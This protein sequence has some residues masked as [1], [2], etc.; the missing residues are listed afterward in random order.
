MDRGLH[1]GGVP[2]PNCSSV[3]AG[4]PRPFWLKTS[5]FFNIPTSKVVGALLIEPDLLNTKIFFFLK[6]VKICLS[7]GPKH[8]AKTGS[9]TKFCCFYGHKLTQYQY[10]W[11]RLI[12][13]SGLNYVCNPIYGRIPVY[14]NVCFR[15]EKSCKNGQNC[16][17]PDLR[18]GAN[19]KV[20]SFFKIFASNFHDY[21]L[22]ASGI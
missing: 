10:F 13:K 18:V 15:P 20:V 11:K 4:R 6:L 14:I 8:D 5:N 22:S 17:Y 7:Y 3:L 21:C 9:A 1:F 16:T 2:Y 19:P 12:C